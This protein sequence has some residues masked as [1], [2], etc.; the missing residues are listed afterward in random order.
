MSWLSP[1]QPSFLL[2]FSL[3]GDL[4][5]EPIL[6]WKRKDLVLIWPQVPD[7]RQQRGVFSTRKMGLDNEDFLAQGMSNNRS[8]ENEGEIPTS[9]GTE[10]LSS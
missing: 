7:Q 1:P 10:L 4:A 5:T 6:I 2:L 9:P 8:L 3:C